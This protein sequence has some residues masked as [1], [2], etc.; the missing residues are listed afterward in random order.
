MSRISKYSLGVVLLLWVVLALQVKA[1]DTA[2]AYRVVN[3][4]ASDSLQGRLTGSEGERKAASFLFNEFKKLGLIGEGGGGYHTFEVI[5]GLKPGEMNYLCDGECPGE[6]GVDYVAASFSA[7]AEADAPLVDAGYGFRMLT[8][9]IKRDDYEGLTVKDKIVLIH[10]GVPAEGK[11]QEWM[12]EHASDREKVMV[13]SDLGAAGVILVMPAGAPLPELHYDK[14]GSSVSIPV[15]YFTQEQG[16]CLE[17]HGLGKNMRMT[18]SLELVKEKSR[19]V[20]GILKGTDPRL[21]DEYIVV[22]AHY[23]HLGLGGPGSGSRMPDTV[24]IH[25][26]A[27][28]NASGVAGVLEVARYFINNRIPTSRSILFVAFSGEEMGLLGSAAFMEN[29]P[30]ATDKIVAMINFDMIGRMNRQSQAISIGGTGTAAESQSIL[31]SLMAL[32]SLKATY[33]PEGFGPSDHASFYAKNIPVFYFN[34]GIHTDY[35][36]PFDRPEK[37][38]YQGLVTISETGARLAQ[39][40]ANRNQ[41]LTFREAG[42]KTRTSSRQG[43]KVTLGIMP[44]F[45]GGDIKGLRVAGVTP[46]GPASMSGMQKGDIIV[47][48]DGKS[49]NDIYEYMNRL[50]GLRKGQ[51]VNVDVMRG[52]EKIILIVDL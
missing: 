41:R 9:S 3:V 11:G 38:N 33:S 25:Y 47:A 52:N 45:T 10:K 8:D 50:K 37:I 22:G 29:P 5:T 36:T 39:T 28:D 21:R 27:D 26:G 30:I 44:D 1:Q 17:Q 19:N 14:V 46:G 35:H 49:V 31:D 16:K 2:L 24:A 20:Y 13:A 34:S 6:Y 51:R 18:V 23:D 15:M 32:V 43:L 40:L 7:S 4:L 48:L 42:P 12:R